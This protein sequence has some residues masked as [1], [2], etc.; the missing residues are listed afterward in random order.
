MK[1]MVWVGL[2][3]AEATTGKLY[4]VKNKTNNP[5][6]WD[7][8]NNYGDKDWGAAFLTEAE[9]KKKYPKAKRVKVFIYEF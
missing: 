8:I 6:G 2:S 5:S 7:F 3:S 1:K 9:F 4:Q